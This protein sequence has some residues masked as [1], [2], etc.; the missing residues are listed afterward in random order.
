[1]PNADTAMAH[2]FGL[3]G[4]RSPDDQMADLAMEAWAAHPQNPFKRCAYVVAVMEKQIGWL[5]VYKFRADISLAAIN[6]LLNEK[7]FAPV[8]PSPK[9]VRRQGAGPQS[10]QGETDRPGQVFGETQTAFA[11]PVLS[12]KDG[13]DRQQD[14]TLRRIATLST[15]YKLDTTIINGQRLGDV[16]TGEARAWAQ[17]HGRTVRFIDALTTNLPIHEP[18]R[19]WVTREEAEEIYARVQSADAA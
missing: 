8:V 10:P 19:K 1:M 9:P 17:N 11:R 4:M 2:A 15:H 12:L 18:I 7:R 5:V 13:A 14:A 3:A 6:A 16:T